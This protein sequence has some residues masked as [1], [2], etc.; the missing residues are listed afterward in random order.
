M[1]EKNKCAKKGVEAPPAHPGPTPSPSHPLRGHAHTHAH[2]RAHTRTLSRHARLHIAR[3]PPGPGTPTLMMR[4]PG[5]L[6]CALATRPPTSTVL[7]A[8]RGVQ[9]AQG[10]SKT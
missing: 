6:P 5:A 9:Q 4:G 2:T 8:Q 3:F 1:H 10:K 7:Q